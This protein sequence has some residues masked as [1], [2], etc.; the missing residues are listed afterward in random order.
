MAELPGCCCLPA[1][2]AEWSA[3]GKTVAKRFKFRFGLHTVR[4]TGPFG[5]LQNRTF[6]FTDP[7]EPSVD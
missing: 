4:M 1:S 3:S 2:I 6:T 7:V 5:R